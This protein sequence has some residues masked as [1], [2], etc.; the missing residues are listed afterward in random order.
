M[1]LHLSIANGFV[2]SKMYD[3]R[4]DLDFHIVF[5]SFLDGD[6]PRRNTL[7]TYKL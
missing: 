3:K 2:S 5:F 1:D 6:V 4:E 7:Q